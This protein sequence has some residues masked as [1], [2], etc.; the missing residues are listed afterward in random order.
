MAVLPALDR[1]RVAAQFMR[2]MTTPSSYT[3]AELNAAIAAAD[4]WV[5][6]NAAAYNT[7]LPVAFRTN[8]SVGHKALLLAYVI[9]RRN[10]K[11][12]ANED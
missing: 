2:E 6:A 8:A 5:E 1:T 3:K 9:M 7:A 11:L 10:G 12:R 4:D